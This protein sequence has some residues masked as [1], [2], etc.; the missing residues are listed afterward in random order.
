MGA[1]GRLKRGFSIIVMKGWRHEQQRS[2]TG[3]NMDRGDGVMRKG[4][5]SLI[6]ARSA[7]C[8]RSAGCAVVSQ[9]GTIYV[10]RS[11]FCPVNNFRNK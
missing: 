9:I 5:S 3:T 10:S 7:A 4:A 1:S 11:T 6:A 2:E 8:R